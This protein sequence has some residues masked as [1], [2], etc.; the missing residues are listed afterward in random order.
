[1]TAGA[2]MA[3]SHIQMPEA[4]RVL[5]EGL[6][7]HFS[8]DVRIANIERKALE[9]SSHHT[10]RLRVIL[11]SGERLRVIFKRLQ[12]GANLYDGNEREV[13]IYR[14]LLAGQLFGAPALY[15]SLYDTTR[16]LYWL[17]LEDVG[18]M[19]LEHCD[20]DEWLPAFRW[21]ARMHSAYWGREEEL[22]A[23]HCLAEHDGQYYAMIAQ[24]SR[25]NLEIAG[26]PG[27]LAQFDALI[28]PYTLLVEQLCGQ[29]R[30]LVHGDIFPKNI[31]VQERWTVRPLDWESA[32]I[33]LAA[34]D[35]ARLLDGW[36]KPRQGFIDAYLTEAE[37]HGVEIDRPSFLL[38]LAS[39]EVV[40]VLWH[41]QW[42]ES[43]CRDARFVRGRLHALERAWSD[44]GE[45]SL[46]A[47]PGVGA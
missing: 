10:D 19:T 24:R 13:L 33:G 18:D 35:L 15:A 44:I 9:V 26:E 16:G 39:C 31:A 27:L 43:A 46:S 2:T 14:R 30:T 25:R 32:G 20:I 28:A 4:R 12:P 42:S 11:E 29:A 6:C 1:M 3:E 40:N 22:R 38:T 17:F 47:T 23:L 8:R 37:M 45:G 5:E 7:A 36:G 21:L 41:L 34:W